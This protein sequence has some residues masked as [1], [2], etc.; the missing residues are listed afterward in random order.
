MLILGAPGQAQEAPVAGPERIDTLVTDAPPEDVVA[1]A[2]LG[3]E[4]VHA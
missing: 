2:E 1:L 3:M 4:V